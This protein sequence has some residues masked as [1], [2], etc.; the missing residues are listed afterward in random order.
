MKKGASGYDIAVSVFKEGNTPI[1]PSIVI[2][3]KL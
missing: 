3:K 2:S 1:L